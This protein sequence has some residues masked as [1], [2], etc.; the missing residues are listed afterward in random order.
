MADDITKLLDE[1]QQVDKE[2]DK[3]IAPEEGK[4]E[5]P[6]Q[7]GEK[8]PPVPVEAEPEEKPAEE[9]A[10]EEAVETGKAEAQEVQA[11]QEQPE[12]KAP[13]AVSEKGMGGKR[14]PGYIVLEK[15]DNPNAKWYVIHTYS[16]HEAR[17]AEN[18]KQRVQTL[19][20][21][22][23]VLEMFIP[24]QDKIE[25][26]GGKK[27]SVTEKIFPGYLLV[28]MILSDPTW[29]AVR[30]T[31][32]V[33]GFVGTGSKPTP[34][35]SAEVETIQRFAAMGAPKFKTKFSVGEAVRI[36][37]GPFADYLGSI[38]SIDEEKGKLSV[39]VSIFGRETPVELDFLQVTK[40]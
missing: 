19:G 35:S 37:D 18:L 2:L 30:T 39:L 33:T 25:I 31:P 21:S 23:E 10:E 4:P 1:E 17:V 13:A 16:G 12:T 8:T 15:S 38:G 3:P 28:K 11:S 5:Q 40:I 20:I 24:T 9:Q 36:I 34:L 26:R 22:G 29:L 27:H 7:T 32:G 6:A 14:L